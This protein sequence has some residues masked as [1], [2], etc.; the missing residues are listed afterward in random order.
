MAQ[1]FKA[2]PA[3]GKVRSAASEKKGKGTMKK[4]ARAIPPK[5]KELVD[6]MTKKRASSKHHGDHFE[7]LA[8]SKVKGALSSILKE[9]AERGE[10]I[11]PE[12][13]AKGR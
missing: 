6:A 8:A 11:T 5:K 9:T 12:Q 13:R 2:K 3:G 1:G 10:A 4:G 7:E